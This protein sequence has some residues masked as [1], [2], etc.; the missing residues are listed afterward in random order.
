MITK[1]DV[2]EFISTKP[3]IAKKVFISVISKKPGHSAIGLSKATSKNLMTDYARAH[4]LMPLVDDGTLSFLDGMSLNDIEIIAEVQSKKDANSWQTALF[5]K[6]FMNQWINLF[7][8]TYELD[9]QVLRDLSQN[10]KD[11]T[12]SVGDGIFWAGFYFLLER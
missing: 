10:D 7:A 11:A 6:P 2:K 12:A 8:K 4:G 9:A 3:A 1:S 5:V